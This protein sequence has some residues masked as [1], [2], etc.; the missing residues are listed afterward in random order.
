MHAIDFVP[1][2]GIYL[3]NHSVGRPPCSSR[4]T[5]TAG[6]LEPWEHGDAEVWP[7]WLQQVAN[8]RSSVAQLLNTD[9]EHI[10]PQS[11][12]SSAL[13]KLIHALPKRADK[14]VVL[15]HEQA[16]PSMGFVLQR[17]TELGW[18]CR[19][20]PAQ[21]DPKA[22]ETW[23][24]AITPDVGAV[25]ITHVHSNT[26]DLTP[27]SDIVSLAQ[28]NN[29]YSIVDIAQSVGAVPIDVSAWNA[30]FVLGSCVKWLCGGPG[31]GFLWAHPQR[32]AD[33]SP[34]DVGWFSHEN[35]FEFDIR[36]FRFASGVLRFWGGTPS[37]T[38]YVLAANS[39]Q[40]LLGIGIDTV[41]RHNVMLCRQLI[42]GLDEQQVRSPLNDE[43]R[44][45]TVV[46]HFGEQHEA[47][48][49]RLRDANVRFDSRSTG[50]RLS[51][52]IYNTRD[53][54]DAVRACF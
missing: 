26:S 21:H 47:I 33:C 40:L 51:P 3:L 19:T 54:I 37:V 1:H 48:L 45:G 44:G 5:L 31:A 30:D 50:I 49:Q 10:C 4:D 18:Q 7:H 25:L 46:L 38:P 20:I 9:A 32:V 39:I 16:F 29:S 35:P 22:M 43:Q 41:R 2:N 53:E 28:A 42:E 36:S 14:P 52:H 12:L 6:F 23:R 24:V 13:G 17:A 34:I 11:N 27:V 15:I 8:F